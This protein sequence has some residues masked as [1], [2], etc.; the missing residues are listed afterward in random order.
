MSAHDALIETRADGTAVELTVGAVRLRLTPEEAERLWDLWNGAVMSAIGS[1]KR[2]RYSEARHRAD[3]AE[4]A[5]FRAKYIDA[6]DTGGGILAAWAV[7][8]YYSGSII[9]QWCPCYP[10]P[11]PPLN[12]PARWLVPYGRRIAHLFRGR[13]SACGKVTGVVDWKVA[14]GAAECPKCMKRAKGAP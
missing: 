14:D 13:N 1:A 5:R 12:L 2:T 7:S 10:Y 3:E 6:V 4:R 8:E 9:V 11:E